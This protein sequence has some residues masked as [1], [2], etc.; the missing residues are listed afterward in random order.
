MAYKQK[1]ATF[2]VGD[3]ESIDRVL[4]M[5]EVNAVLSQ[6]LKIRVRGLAQWILSNH[7]G[8]PDGVI[9]NKIEEL[10]EELEWLNIF[11]PKF[12]ERLRFDLANGLNWELQK[13]KK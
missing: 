6:E 13:A 11:N 4:C 5:M 10:V 9:R 2:N 12:I 8:D 7:K 3:N 1:S